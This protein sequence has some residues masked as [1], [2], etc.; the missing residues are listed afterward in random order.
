MKILQIVSL[1]ITIF[2][3]VNLGLIG[4]FDFNFIE[5]VFNIKDFVPI[6]YMLIGISG[7]INIKTLIMLIKSKKQ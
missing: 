5:T 2:G 3:A 7:L 1:C 6:L 4:F